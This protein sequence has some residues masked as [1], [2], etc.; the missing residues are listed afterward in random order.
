MPCLQVTRGVTDPGNIRVFTGYDLPGCQFGT[1]RHCIGL[2]PGCLATSLGEGC[3]AKRI[4]GQHCKLR[5]I[6]TISV[7]I[8]PKDF[9]AVD[10]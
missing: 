1:K 5:I 6:Q 7:M 3:T 4:T 2:G 9:L 10:V 8:K